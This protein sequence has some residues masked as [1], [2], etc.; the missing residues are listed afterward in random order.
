MAR[1]LL[2]GAG[3]LPTPATRQLGF[4][5]LR[6]VHFQHALADDHTVRVACLSS[7]ADSQ[8]EGPFA[9]VFT[10]DPEAPGWLERLRT[11]AE[12]ADLIVSAGPYLP[13]EAACLIAGDRPVWAD[14]PGD[15]FAE[16]QAVSLAP[17]A[18]LDP[19][20]SAAA[21]SAAMT[22]LSRADRISVISERQRMAL[23]G[24]L[25]LLGRLERPPG[26][27]GAVVPIGY[28]LDLPQ[29]LPRRRRPGSPFVIALCGGF[30]TWLNDE[31][32]A[33]ALT[34]S[35]Q[36][37]PELSVVVTGG[38]LRG[39]YTNGF[40]RF[41]QWRQQSPF[42]SRVSIHGWVQHDALPLVLSDAHL[43]LYLDRPGCEALLGSRTRVHLFTWMGME[44]LGTPHSE[45]TCDMAAE[46]VMHATSADGAADAIRRIA[47]A[48]SDGKMAR[49]AHAWLRQRCSPEQT[50]LPL[51]RWAQHPQRTPAAPHLDAILVE[52]ARL[53]DALRQIHQSPT[54]RLMGRLHRLGRRARAA[55]EDEG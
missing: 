47:A 6:L 25:G 53:R 1:V 52:N 20:R 2:I 27:L 21:R 8:P 46:G 19:V 51:R 30:N 24:Q 32:I 7:G 11:L 38:E 34:E 18:P 37:L 14:L 3:P 4:P 45:L 9:G 26:G 10:I 48:G 55:R 13:G 15:P 43:G 17:G 44:V 49:C 16:L 33:T 41:E 22:V 31:A 54:W 23:L 50:V 35:L 28:T 40:A 5:Q 42:R 36:A 29:G 12:P 39:H